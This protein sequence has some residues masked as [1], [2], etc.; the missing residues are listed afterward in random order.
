MRRAAILSLV[1][2]QVVVLAYMAANREYIVRYGQ[3]IHLRTAPVDPRAVFRGDFVRL[4]YELSRVDKSLTDL[5]ESA[6]K[7]GQKVYAELSPIAGDLYGITHLSDTE[8]TSD[9]YMRG[10]VV[11]DYPSSVVY[12]KYGIEQYFV[13]QGTGIDIETRRGNRDTLQIPMEVAVALSANGTAVTKDR[14]WSRLGIQLEVIRTPRRD[15]GA[16]TVEVEQ[17]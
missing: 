4:D 16:D 17:R 5:S 13:Q 15:A 12:V 7:K 1:I 11:R 2:F 3:V 9:V 10:R 8:P 6:H 14:R